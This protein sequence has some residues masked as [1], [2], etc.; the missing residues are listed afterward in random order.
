MNV[1]KF[2]IKHTF[3]M[4]G[5]KVRICMEAFLRV[6][7]AKVMH[8]RKCHNLAN[9][10]GDDGSFVSFDD[11]FSITVASEDIFKPTGDD[12]ILAVLDIPF[13]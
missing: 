9:I 1:E 2:F 7:I 10:F 6:N 8:R 5:A 13:K 4:L 3:T 11:P 12:N